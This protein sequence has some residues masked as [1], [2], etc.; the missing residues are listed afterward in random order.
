MKNLIDTHSHLLKKYYN[1]DLEFLIK[2]I[3]KKMDFLLNV[4]TDFEEIEEVIDI[5]KKNKKI[6]PV[7]GI[8]PNNSNKFLE[9]KIKKLEEIIIKNK[10]QIIAIGEIGLDFY[11]EHNKN[12]QT[13]MF[14]NQ[15]ELARKYKFSVI[16]HLRNSINEAYEI[17][18][19][20][21]DVNFLI[22]SWSG[23]LEQTKNFLSLKNFW[24]SYNGIIT[25]KNGFP[26]KETIKLIPKDKLLFETDCPYLSPVPF[27]GKKNDPI[28]I[29]HIIEKASEILS[30]KKDELNL[31]NKKNIMEFLKLKW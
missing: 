5:S 31:L 1:K 13:K 9:E 8:H 19:K 4:G 30:I 6:L 25:F 11:R 22:H 14:I 16:I 3:N 18:K 17:L 28:K 10:K 12:E 21:E 15:I 2:E 26:Q 24:F 23:D 27:R 20:Y 29:I 7:I